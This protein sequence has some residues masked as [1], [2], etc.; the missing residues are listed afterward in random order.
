[1]T[2]AVIIDYSVTKVGE[3]WNKGLDDLIFETGYPLIKK[4]GSDEIEALYIGN[5]LSEF[6]N[7]QSNLGSYALDILGLFDAEAFHI[8]SAEASSAAAVYQ[9]VLAIKSGR[10]NVVLAGGVEKMTDLLYRK[11]IEGLSIALNADLVR[12]TGLNLASVAGIMA[13]EYMKRYGVTKKMITSLS[14]QDHKN[15]VNAPHAQYRY[16]I[17]LDQAINAPPVADPLTVYDVSPIGDG[18]AFLLL[19][20]R[21]Y[22]EDN[23]LP[24]VEIV[25]MGMATNTLSIVDRDDILEFSATSKACEKALNQAGID[26]SDINVFEINDDFS[27]TGILSLEALGLFDEGE[28]AENV[29]RGNTSLTSR[30]PINTFGGLK[31]RGHPVGATGAYQIAEI[32]MQLTS[33]AGS[34]QVNNAIYGLTQNYGGLDSISIVMIFRKGD[35]YA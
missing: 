17:T 23:N 24:Y 35:Y 27:I 34:N 5:M 25:G 19:A 1:M 7:I 9:A 6:A 21:E 32:Y 33:K 15:A 31:A 16:E 22:A 2:E 30:K 3:H 11:A 26:L 12:M 10:Y 28:A 4:Y 13:K 18:G 29:Y 8:N 20:S 14:V